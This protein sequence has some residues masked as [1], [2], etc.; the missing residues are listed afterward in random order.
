MRRA[1]RVDDNQHEIVDALRSVGAT[2]QSLAAVGCGVPDLLV[3]FRGETYLMEV[4]NSALPPSARRLTPAE[5]AWHERWRGRPVVIIKDI[6]EALA[7]LGIRVRA[8][9]LPTKAKGW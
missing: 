9:G 6:D 1:A 3:G 7:V 4:K 5:S 2:V 8:V